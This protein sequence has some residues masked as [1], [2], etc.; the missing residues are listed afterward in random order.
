M[1]EKLDCHDTDPYNP[2]KMKSSQ[3]IKLPKI[4]L[5]KSL[6]KSSSTGSVPSSPQTTTKSEIEQQKDIYCNLNPLHA[7]HDIS[8][9]TPGSVPI[10]HLVTRV[11]QQVYSELENI[12]DILPRQN[13]IEKRRTLFHYFSTVKTLFSAI[14]AIRIW[15][16]YNADDILHAQNEIVK[17]KEKEYLLNQHTFTFLNELSNKFI[18]LVTPQADIVTALDLFRSNG[19]LTINWLPRSMYIDDSSTINFKKLD[20]I[21]RRKLFH[22]NLKFKVISI[23]NGVATFSFFNNIILYMTLTCHTQQ[24]RL[25]KIDL[26]DIHSKYSDLNLTNLVPFLQDI[27]NQNSVDELYTIL[28]QFYISIRLSILYDQAISLSS[29]YN[30]IQVS[31]YDEKSSSFEITLC[32]KKIVIKQDSK[33]LNSYIEDSSVNLSNILEYLSKHLIKERLELIVSNINTS[34]WSFKIDDNMKLLLSR[35]QDINPFAWIEFNIFNQSYHIYYQDDMILQILSPIRDIDKFPSI[36]NIYKQVKVSQW[37]KEC[38][39]CLFNI[40]EN[41]NRI[42][43]WITI[44]YSRLPMISLHIFIDSGIIK[45]YFSVDGKHLPEQLFTDCNGLQEKFINVW[46]IQNGLNINYHLSSDCR[47]ITFTWNLDSLDKFVSCLNLVSTNANYNNGILT[48]KSRIK[49]DVI[50]EFSNFRKTILILFHV[51]QQLM[52]LSDIKAEIPDERTI[53]IWIYDSIVNI[54]IFTHDNINVTSN[55]KQCIKKLISWILI[56]SEW[57][58]VAL[59]ESWNG[60]IKIAEIMSNS[61]L[62]VKVLNEQTI[63]IDNNLLIEQQDITGFFRLTSYSLLPFFKVMF[64]RLKEDLN[65][66][67]KKD[68]EDDALICINQNMLVQNMT[69]LSNYL[70]FAK[71]WTRLVLLIDPSNINGLRQCIWIKIDEQSSSG[72]ITIE[73][74]IWKHQ[75]WWNV[76]D[77]Q[78]SNQ[79][80]PLDLKNQTPIFT[81]E[82]GI[83]LVKFLNQLLAVDN[84]LQT[85]NI[86]N[87]ARRTLDVIALWM[88]PAIVMKDIIKSIQSSIKLPA[89]NLS[90]FIISNYEYID[91]LFEVDHQEGSV[92]IFITFW[93]TNTI[94]TKLKY[95]WNEKKLYFFCKDNPDIE[96]KLNQG[97]QQAVTKPNISKMAC[98]L[99]YSILYLAKALYIEL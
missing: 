14:L 24:W 71:Y 60:I 83:T 91:H 76:I 98:N 43:E 95:S 65:C 7:S 21:I 26:I 22:S 67:Q 54:H 9:I 96:S 15:F 74:H 47:D 40:S 93:K 77:N 23:N 45:C 57:N 44:K 27:I 55:M 49:Q 68:D 31:I 10:S 92:T 35:Y 5:P 78:W 52:H 1:Y 84:P 6:L 36:D 42:D 62:D 3:E 58:M 28:H 19:I 50:D 61:F 37:K 99:Y 12:L 39:T 64:K 82:D 90:H 97:L 69:I 20:H 38:D 30:M 70:I 17:I 29:L 48:F 25:L 13:N 53:N 34:G 11:T 72:V 56:S 51:N 18:S 86:H 94:S 66:Y 79:I 33:E 4:V 81:F 2:D 63:L 8:I 75:I 73:S 32:Q 41:P 85:T 59:L 16:K 80:I 89:Q 87:M 88:L 46:I